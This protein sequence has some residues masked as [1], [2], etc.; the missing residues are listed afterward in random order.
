MFVCKYW[1]SEFIK[2]WFYLVVVFVLNC[3][4]FAVHPQH[5]AMFSDVFEGSFVWGVVLWLK[6]GQRRP[7]R[8]F[9]GMDVGGRCMYTISSLYRSIYT[10]IYPLHKLVT[11]PPNPY[12][13]L[14]LTFGL[15]V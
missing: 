13:T 9:P 15:P 2:Q 11:E 8:A 14:P 5:G 10:H 12:L 1:A 6:F 3:T 4:V 7:L